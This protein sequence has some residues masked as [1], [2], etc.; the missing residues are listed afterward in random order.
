LLSAVGFIWVIFRM[1]VSLSAVG[2]LSLELAVPDW[3]VHAACLVE[4]CSGTLRGHTKIRHPEISAHHFLC[5]GLVSLV[6][7][8][9]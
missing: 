6:T 9:Y 1:I 5:T 7:S 4:C 8:F 2:F 3:C